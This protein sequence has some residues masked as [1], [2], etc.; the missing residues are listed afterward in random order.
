M[1]AL[2]VQAQ[3]QP[4]ERPGVK[5]H[6]KS[7]QLIKALLIIHMQLIKPFKCI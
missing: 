4:E 3:R 6:K 5:Q 7:L 2:E 1:G